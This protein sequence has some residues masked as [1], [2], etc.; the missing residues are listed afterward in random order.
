MRDRISAT[1]SNNKLRPASSWCSPA[2]RVVKQSNGGSD[3]DNAIAAAG[4]VTRAQGVLSV[5]PRKRIR[6]LREDIYRLIEGEAAR[7]SRARVACRASDAGDEIG[8]TF[9]SS[10]ALIL[11]RL[12]RHPR[13]GPQERE[14]LM[15]AIQAVGFALGTESV[16][17]ERSNR[18]R[19]R[20]RWV[21]NIL[22][23]AMERNEL[24]L[25]H[26]EFFGRDLLD[27]LSRD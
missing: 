17:M 13:L 4:R 14:F 5:A 20:A 23:D 10:A 12:E 1:K 9:F 22:A 16:R 6:T 27:R 26:S 3:H 18:L 25:L 24:A 11:E 2:M 21:A 7:M 15:C 8:Q 19:R